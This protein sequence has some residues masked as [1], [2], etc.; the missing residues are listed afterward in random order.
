MIPFPLLQ[1]F[2]QCSKRMGIA[3]DHDWTLPLWCKKLCEVR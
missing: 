2:K 1:R 3:E